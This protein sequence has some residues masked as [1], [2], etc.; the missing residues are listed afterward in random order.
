VTVGLLK[1]DAV[2]DMHVAISPYYL[3]LFMVKV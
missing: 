2:N 1:I 3:H